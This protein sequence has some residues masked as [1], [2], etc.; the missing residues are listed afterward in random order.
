MIIALACDHAGCGLKDELKS[1]LAEKNIDVIDCGTTS[2]DMTVDYPDWGFKAA[3]AVASRKADLGILCCGTGIGMSIVANKV[4]GIRAALCHD[5]FTAVMSRR[6]NNANILVLGSR[7][8]GS[9]LAKEIVDSWLSEEFEGNRHGIR[10]GKI[11]DYENLH[12]KKEPWEDEKNTGRT[13]IMNHP[14]IRHKVGIMRNKNTPSKDFRDLVQE[15]AGLMVY[16]ITR[17]LSL[18]E[19]EI[20]TPIAKTKAFT[21]AGKKLAII[22]ILRAGL[23]MAD[24]ILKIV[25]N[26]KVGHVG[27]YRDPKTLKPVEYYC[28]L[29]NDLAS[30]DIIVVDPMLATGGSAADAVSLIKQKGG[31]KISM[32]CLIAAPEGIKV[33]HKTHPEIDIYIAALDS[34]LNDHGYIVPGLGDAGDR[35]FGTK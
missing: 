32:V 27:L 16:E 26:A 6:H 35:L 25:P 5:H 23:G 24:G 17:N 8:T 3:E 4:K 18:E 12:G 9:G 11:S 1:Y 7:V 19:I 31:K 21:L 14:L 15:I 13:V 33:F 2:S 20:E 10:L 30:R 34:H 28:K 22:P 29:P